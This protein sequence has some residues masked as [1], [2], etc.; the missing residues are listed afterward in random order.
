MKIGRKGFMLAEV[1]VVS[2]VVATV[3]VTLFTGINNV[4]SAYETR[5]R[6]FDIDSLYIAME[7][8]NILLDSGFNIEML[9]GAQTVV[10]LAMENGIDTNKMQDFDEFYDDMDY[11]NLN[12]YIALYD[13]DNVS[14]L[15]T[16]NSNINF[17]DYIDYLTDRFDFYLDYDYVIVVE[18]INKNDIDDCYY[19]ALRLNY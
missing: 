12:H 3:L 1:V 7:V 6:Y 14:N 11:Y 13:K 16:L 15:D 2:V 4:S 5:N 18:R 10:D 8:N 17:K 19:Y 9:N